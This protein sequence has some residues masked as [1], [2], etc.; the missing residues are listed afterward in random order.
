L[1]RAVCYRMCLEVVR[2]YQ[3]QHTSC[4]RS[5]RQAQGNVEEVFARA[6]RAEAEGAALVDVVPFLRLLS[7]SL[8]MEAFS[9]IDV[10]LCRHELWQ[11]IVPDDDKTCENSVLAFTLLMSEGALI[12]AKLYSKRDIYPRKALRV[13]I[14][15]ELESVVVADPQCVHT[16]WSW[17]HTQTY[18]GADVGAD[19]R[20]DGRMMRLQIG[21]E[22]ESSIEVLESLHASIRRRIKSRGVQTH[23]VNFDD[24]N[25]DWV[26]GLM[27]RR[28][29]RLAMSVAEVVGTLE[30]AVADDSDPEEE[31][32]EE[33]AKSGRGGGGLWR[34]FVRH[35]TLGTKGKP[36]LAEIASRYK[37]ISDELRAELA[38]LAL[39]ATSVARRAD[40]NTLPAG[41][42]AF[43]PTTRLAE[44]TRERQRRDAAAVVIRDAM[45]L[46]LAL[47][48]CHG[49]NRDAAH[50]VAMRVALAMP[51]EGSDAFSNALQE[52]RVHLRIHRKVANEERQRGEL[53]V[54]NWVANDGQRLLSTL[55]GELPLLRGMASTSLMPVPGRG[56]LAIFEFRPSVKSMRDAIGRVVELGPQLNL[57]SA[58]HA[59]FQ[60][61]SA[62]ILHDDCD[63]IPK[64]SGLP[65]RPCASL[66]FC[67][68]SGAGDALWKF[69]NAFLRSLKSSFPPSQTALRA[70]LA[71]RRVICRFVG[72]KRAPDDPWAIADMRRRG[73]DM[74][75][76][77]AEVFYAVS[78]MSWSPYSPS[79]FSMV[80]SADPSHSAEAPAIALQSIGGRFYQEIRGLQLLRRDAQW[81]VQFYELRVGGQPLVT[82]QPGD[83]IAIPIR[84]TAMISF[85][86]PQRG[87]RGRRHV[88]GEAAAIE[89]DDDADEAEPDGPAPVEDELAIMDAESSESGPEDE[90]PPGA[91]PPPPP[92]PPP[93]VAEPRAFHGRVAA[94]TSVRFGANNCSISF[95]ASDNRFEAVCRNVNHLP[96]GKC[97]L[98]RTLP[99]HDDGVSAKGRMLG[100]MMAWLILGDCDDVGNKADH[101]NPFLI[102]GIGYE[103]RVHAR[104]FLKTLAGAEDLLACERPLR[105]G[106]SEEP[107][108]QP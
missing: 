41:W 39:A 9:R 5:S 16:K 2:I 107:V 53:A 97:R 20:L 65:K 19:K 84:N 18:L 50:A 38:P 64:P 101:T 105:D 99:L 23:G 94:L 69:H 17:H 79:F 83:Q 57:A 106:E 14:D 77:D 12:N 30:A 52:G 56:E 10:L 45:G 76:F 75:S 40:C 49:E 108:D 102:I 1:G 91:P 44:Q 4:T 87:R 71:Q 48:D 51:R 55:L 78:H 89:D 67:V 95:Y 7:G 28:D 85:W 47:Q 81:S 32:E 46:Q 66:G 90:E 21:I 8:E 98:T 54:R 25:A 74:G 15:G 61:R 11:S 60:R 104:D 24:L 35:D 37:D 3:Q 22:S 96:M 80:R 70:L 27:R 63:P 68:C 33:A 100:L 13:D 73:E 72:C 34:A 43:G 42:C 82:F 6:Q 86:P 58:L 93:P 26:I 36:D 29:S 92:A 59:S 31:A 103:D 62:P 88:E